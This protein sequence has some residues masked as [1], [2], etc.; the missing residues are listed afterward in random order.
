MKKKLALLFAITLSLALICGAN[1]AMTETEDKIGA[2]LLAQSQQPTSPEEFIDNLELTEQQKEQI[3]EILDSYRP[4][5]R[6][7]FEEL[8]QELQNLRDTTDPTAS[9][10]EIRIARQEVVRVRQQLSN[11]LFEELMAIRSELT[12]E[13]REQINLRLQELYGQYN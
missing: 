2:R 9:A 7:T 3:Q 5:I 12:V 11:L 4:E 1:V 10:D 8:Q 13:Q 6:S